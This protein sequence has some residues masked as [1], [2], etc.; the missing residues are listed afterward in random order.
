MSSVMSFSLLFLL[1]FI[2][3][4]LLLLTQNLDIVSAVSAVA[5][6]LGN[7]GP[8]LNALG[9]TKPFEPVSEMAKCLLSAC[10]LLGRLELYTMISLLFPSFWRK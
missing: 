6:T 8:G 9:P 1:V 5:C 7:I 10:M 2:T 3:A 4:T